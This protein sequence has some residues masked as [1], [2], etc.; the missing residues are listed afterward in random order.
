MLSFVALYGREHSVLSATERRRDLVAAGA[1]DAIY[2]L[3]LRGFAA[4]RALIVSS[5]VERAGLGAVPLAG[6][7]LAMALHFCIV[8]HSL[9]EEHGRQQRRTGRWILA[10]S[11]LAGWVIGTAMPISEATLTRPFAVLG[12]GIVITSLKAELPDDRR[13][14]LWPSLL[15]ASADALRLQLA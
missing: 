11:G 13:R 2:R 9:G 1:G 14:R 8:D 7:T 15:G 12:G 5:V 6:Y 10:A 3:H 4:Y